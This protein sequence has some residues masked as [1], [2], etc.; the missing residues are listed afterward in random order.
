MERIMKPSTVKTNSSV[1][2]VFK[3]VYFPAKRVRAGRS[4]RI[5]IS[6]PTD[7]KN[8]ASRNFNIFINTLSSQ[9]IRDILGNPILEDLEDKADKNSVSLSDLCVEALS[10]HFKSVSKPK[11]VGNQLL[12][13][14]FRD[15]TDALTTKEP[16]ANLGVTFQDSLRKGIFGWYPYVEG[17]SASYTR[18]AILRY[19]PQKVFDP[20]GGSGTTQL[21]SSLLGIPS[22]FC[23][24]N[25]FMSFVAK[26][27]VLVAQEAKA[28]FLNFQKE[29]NEFVAEI[30][31][32]NFEVHT[33]K[34]DL[35]C[36]HAA[37]PD[38]DFFQELHIRQLLA[39][40]Q[41]A[42]Q[43]ERRCTR[44]LLLLACAANVVRS[45]NMTRRADLR[46]RRKDEY[47]NRV[48]DVPRFISDSVNRMVS[49]IESL[50]DKTAE[51]T[52]VS[53][54]ARERKDQYEG[55]FDFALT[56]PPYLNGTNYFRNTK[57]ELWFLDFMKSE[58]ELSQFRKQAIVAGINNVSLKREVKTSFETVE[59]V[60]RKLDKVAKDKRIPSLVRQYFSD[61]H[62][63]MSGV[64]R[65]LTRNGVFL[66]D[67]GDSKF[68]GVHV[69]THDLLISVAS[70][71]GLKL[72]QQHLLARRHS[73][74]KT[75]LVQ[76]ELIF[77]KA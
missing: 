62:Q 49:D 13:P 34:V 71:A 42:T 17:F 37:F 29:C 72:E 33:S 19:K 52:F 7:L 1:E 53:A 10:S 35:S 6:I 44:D 26:S 14:C 36:Y 27:K 69:P 15:T 67:I 48:V 43:F 57:L 45:S 56:S 24:V 41:L 9:R 65:Y 64:G 70:S 66:L 8:P 30:C 51:T 28:Q 5:T 2:F 11:K 38:R 75:P 54:D 23:E 63:V 60:A 55:S 18:D 59:K 40:K 46:R 31:S 4:T 76:M 74:D 61:M 20:F 21:A 22:Y 12:L 50:P 25:P 73:R 58:K 47:K 16:L 77:R 32:K 3:Q 68:Y 39:A